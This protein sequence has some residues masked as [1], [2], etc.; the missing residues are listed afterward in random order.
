MF[1][2]FTSE[3][4]ARCQFGWAGSEWPGLNQV[5]PNLIPFYRLIKYKLDSNSRRVGLKLS[6]KVKKSKFDLKKRFYM[7]MSIT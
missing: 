4:G 1:F 7:H 5:R 3:D 2:F 6:Y